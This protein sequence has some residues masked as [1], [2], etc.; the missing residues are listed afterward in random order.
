MMT[1]YLSKYVVLL[2]K[3]RYLYLINSL[4]RTVTRTEPINLIHNGSHVTRKHCL[5]V[6]PPPPKKKINA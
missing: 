3:I 2:W 6:V 4:R 5:G 1:L